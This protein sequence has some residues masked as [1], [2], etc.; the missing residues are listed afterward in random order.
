MNDPS[1]PT[2][3]CLHFL[4]GSGRSWA[5]L[6]DRL[7][8]GFAVVGLDL[9]GFGAAAA[10]PGYGVSAM[11]DHVAA[12]IRSR[13]PGRWLLAGHSMGGKVAAVIARRAEDGEAGLEGLEGLVLLA[14]SPPAPEPMAESKREEMLGW[15]T[16]DPARCRRQARAYIRANAG[17]H[18][19]AA[20]HEALVDAM[21]PARLD[22]W[23]AWLRDGSREDWRDRIGRL[24]TPALVLSG[25]EDDAL[26]EEAQTRTTLPHLLQAEAVTLPEAAHLLPLERPDIVARLITERF[27]PPPA[28]PEAYRA[29]IE[30]PRVST[31]TRAVLLARGAVP[32]PT[33]V[34]SP[35]E[36][37]TLRAVLARVIPQDGPARIDLATALASHLPG[38]GDGW[39]PLELPPDLPAWSAGLRT[40]ETIGE[41]FAGRDG[42]EQDALLQRVADGKGGGSGPAELDGARMQA[43]FEEVTA[44][45]VRLHTAHPVTMARMGYSGI[46]YGGDGPDKPGFTALGIGQREAW[47]PA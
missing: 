37:G 24:R 26:G 10:T 41:G 39:R 15:F 9:P 11:A 13:M 12:A 18:L 20:E 42:A 14:G 43:W 28:V 16:G 7:H 6:A 46:G 33:D 21:L 31:G 17:K 2:L 38:A 4:G 29:L 44:E 45:A 47:E 5:A 8:P 25:A 30:S 22:A 34:L 40:L 23:V 36:C 35:A 19:P 3:F 27:A 32:A 1:P